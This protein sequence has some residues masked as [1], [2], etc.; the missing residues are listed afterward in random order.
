MAAI[1]DISLLVTLNS[2]YSMIECLVS[3]A[4]SELWG[5]SLQFRRYIVCELIE[6]SLHVWQPLSWIYY[7]QLL[8]TTF[9]V[10]TVCLASWATSECCGCHWNFGDLKSVR[11]DT[12]ERQQIDSPLHHR[13]S[14]IYFD[15]WGYIRFHIG[16]FIT[17]FKITI[18]LSNN[19]WDRMSRVIKTTKR[20]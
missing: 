12:W 18:I 14:A 6:S 1:F 3:W 8:P 13:F 17:T 4:T 9:A 10:G 11:R 20:N 2:T 7:L 16:L 19:Q 5:L 15:G